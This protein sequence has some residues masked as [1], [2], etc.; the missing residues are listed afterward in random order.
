MGGGGAG[1][2]PQGDFPWCVL[3]MVLAIFYKVAKANPSWTEDDPSL[4]AQREHDE[5]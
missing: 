4:S 5:D 2:S 3:V 1:R